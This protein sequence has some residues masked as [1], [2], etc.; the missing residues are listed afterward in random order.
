[1]KG[2]LIDVIDSLMR[3]LGLWT[4]EIADK[5]LFL[6]G[7]VRCGVPTLSDVESARYIISH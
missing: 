6:L 3:L 4:E 5:A 7:S 1:M 2:L